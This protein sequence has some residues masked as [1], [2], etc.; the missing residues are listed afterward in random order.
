MNIRRSARSAFLIGS[1]LSEVAGASCKSEAPAPVSVSNKASEYI[2]PAAFLSSLTGFQQRGRVKTGR[3]PMI[4]TKRLLHNT[5]A[6]DAPAVLALPRQL[7]PTRALDGEALRAAFDRA[8]A[9]AS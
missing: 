4:K 3:S 7:R 6:A 9:A 5:A 1:S 8:L 2:I